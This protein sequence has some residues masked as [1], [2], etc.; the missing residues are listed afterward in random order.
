M[1]RVVPSQIVSYIGD[2]FGGGLRQEGFHVD[3][4]FAD[5]VQALTRLIDELPSDLIALSG[6][7]YNQFVLSVETLRTAL[8]MWSA[9]VATNGQFHSRVGTS[10]AR[11]HAAL[12]K[13]QDYQ[14]PAATTS[15]RSSMTH[16]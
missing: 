15:F 12:M 2:V 13:L 1:P 8:T 11:L 3:P 4:Q 5:R 14:V 6:Q 9:K 16:S 10:V 7:D